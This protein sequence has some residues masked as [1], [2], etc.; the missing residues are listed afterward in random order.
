V[1]GTFCRG[2]IGGDFPDK[3]EYCYQCEVFKTAVDDDPVREMEER[4]YGLMYLLGDR[5]HQVE[6]MYQGSELQRQMLEFLLNLSR[7]ALSSL[8]LDALLELVVSQVVGKVADFA[9]FFIV[10]KDGNLE[11]HA[12]KGFREGVYPRLIVEGGIDFVQSVIDG[13][14]LKTSSDLVDEP[15]VEAQFLQEKMPTSIIGVP[16]VSQERKLGLL[17]AGTFRKEPY[18]DFDKQVIQVASD[19]IALAVSNARMYASVSRM[20]ATDGLTGLSN[21]RSFFETV[22]KELGRSRRYGHPLSVIMADIDNFKDFNDTYGHPQG[23]KVLSEIAKVIRDSVRSV[24][25]PARYGGEEFAVLLPETSL[26]TSED[27]AGSAMQ[28]AERMRKAVEAHE[29]EGRPGH[30]DVRLT[31]SLGIAAHP[32]HASELSALVNAADEALYRA[33]DF[34]RNRVELA[35]QEQEQ[36][37]IAARDE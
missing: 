6:E 16:L 12:S 5:E 29:F 3:L 27:I 9:V 11:L 32:A 8:E 4:F 35:K 19:Q 21:H 15:W 20:A 10:D 26:G 1:D 34:G 17:L 24:D 30:R 18:S 37:G 25:T 22:E 23:D 36:P 31:I 33:K 13:E 28:V 14:D 2:E 7:K